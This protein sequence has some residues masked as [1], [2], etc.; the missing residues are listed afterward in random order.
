LT[1]GRFSRYRDR[2]RRAAALVALLLLASCG[3]GESAGVQ[4]EAGRVEGDLQR[5]VR[6]ISDQAENG[7]AAIEQALEKEGAAAFANRGN[8][9]NESGEP[10]TPDLN[11]SVDADAGNASR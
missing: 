5:Q 2:M 10:E 1:K 3:G 9:F 7:A 8:P 6:R 4:N 11:E